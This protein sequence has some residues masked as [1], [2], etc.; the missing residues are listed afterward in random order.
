IGTMNSSDFSLYGNSSVL[1]INS[2][3][4]DSFSAALT[5]NIVAMLVWLA[6]SVLNCSM[7]STFRKHC[8][9][10]E[11]PRYIMFISMVI[12]DAVQLTL[13]TA[14]Y[15]VSYAFSKILASACCPLIMTAVTT[16]RFTPLILAGMALERYISIC[17][18]LHHSQICTAPRTLSIISLVFLLSF[19]PPLTDLIITIAKEPAPIF[20]TS[21]FCDH[22]LL[23]PDRSVYYK[24]LRL[25]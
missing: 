21:I 15:V 22:S 24:N 10:Y 5:K 12:N 2:V 18:P 4:R 17:F 23:F 3:P 11:D 20:Q 9:F 7:V 8:F 16:T 19:T 1:L 14:L 13:V 6:L 25:R